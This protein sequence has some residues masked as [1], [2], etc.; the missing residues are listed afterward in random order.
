MDVAGESFGDWLR[1][2]PVK[3]G[4]PAVKLFDG[5][6]K[7]NQA[8][9]AAVID[10]DTGARDLQQCAD[11]V[12]RLRAEFLRARGR[13]DEISFR[14]TNGDPARWSDWR[15]GRRPVVNGN[16]VRWTG[17]APA[18]NS[19]DAFRSYLNFVFTYAGSHSL[20]RELAPL[21]NRPVEPGDVFIQGG[22]P[23]HAVIVLDVARRGDA[24][25]FL[26]AQ[27]YMPAQDMH[28]LVNPTS[29][30]LGPWYADMRGQ[31]LVTPEWTFPSRSLRR[32]R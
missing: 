30:E 2:L 24:R 21:G 20:E 22:F 8:A 25:A 15:G 5:R 16:R 17:S 28:V 11:A 6:D 1:A 3:P 12:M 32:F 13:D 7:P 31:S 19:Y 4:R 29:S 9:H 14:L 26:L 10:S 18:S 27:S 23:G